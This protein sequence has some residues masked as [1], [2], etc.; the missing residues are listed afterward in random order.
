MAK[1]VLIGGSRAKIRAPEVAD[2]LE[3]QGYELIFNPYGRSLAEP[4]LVEMIKGM[5]AFVAG[6]EIVT[7]AVMAAGAPTLKIIARQGAG[8]NT[9]D[10]NAAQRYGIA[11]T[12][13]PETNSKSVA[14]LTFGLILAIARR[15]PQMDRMVREELWTRHVGVELPGKVLGIVG[16]GNVGGEVAKRAVGFDMKIIAYDIRLRQDCIDKYGVVYLPLKEVLAQAD[17]LSLHIPALPETE[18]MI[19]LDSLCTMKNTAYLINMARGSLV[20]ED[21]LY[22]A[23]T[24]EIIAGAALDVFSCEPLRKSR[25]TELSNVLLTPHAGAFTNEAIYRAGFT[26]AQEVVRVLSGLKPQCPVVL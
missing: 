12:I 9:I 6:N 4:E 26:A 13:A 5:D 17:F 18:G 14:D 25:L 15:I 22:T 3:Q 19:N 21:D 23:L 10:V 11:V 16:T 1:K 8:Y 20:V 2:I 24:Q 7:A